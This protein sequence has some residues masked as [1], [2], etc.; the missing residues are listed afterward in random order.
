MQIP[1]SFSNKGKK[2]REQWVWCADDVTA[3]DDGR[4]DLVQK[5]LL[6]F[7][8]SLTADAA[9]GGLMSLGSH[10]FFFPNFV[11]TN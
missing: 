3:A 11:G 8:C 9:L 4:F 5:M 2:M 1:C 7:L 10:L 6:K